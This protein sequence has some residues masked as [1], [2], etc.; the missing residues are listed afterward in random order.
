ML[1]YLSSGRTGSDVRLW[2]KGLAF[3][4]GGGVG[5]LL[6]FRATLFKIFYC[7]S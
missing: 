2:V 3:T 7:H 4:H 5:P 1:E 6:D